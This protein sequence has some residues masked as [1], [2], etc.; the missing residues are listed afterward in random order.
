MIITHFAR[1]VA[2]LGIIV[3]VLMFWQGLRTATPTYTEFRDGT[4]A[5]FGS[6]VLGLLAEINLSLRSK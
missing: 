2:F 6:L 3:A 1:V 5:L 4:Y